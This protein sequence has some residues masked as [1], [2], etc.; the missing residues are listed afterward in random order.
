HL[1]PG[2]GSATTTATFTLSLSA[3]SSQP[4]TVHFATADGTA[5][6]GKDYVASS[7][8][9]TFTPGQTQATITITVM[10]DPLAT[11]DLTFL[12]DL[13]NPLN[14]LLGGNA[15]AAARQSSGATEEH[16]QSAPVA[17]FSSE[18]NAGG[19]ENAPGHG[20]KSGA[21]AEVLAETFAALPELLLAEGP[22]REGSPVCP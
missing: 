9:V 7:G 17:T 11:A 3:P 22:V 15:E 5:I 6:A 8:T 2:G 20:A 4:V 21:S 13:S 14:G 12:V 10:A 16:H 19:G 1:P 18:Q